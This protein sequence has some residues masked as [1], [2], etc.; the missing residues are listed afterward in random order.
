MK[1]LVSTEFIYLFPLGSI[2]VSDPRNMAARPEDVQE[3]APQEYLSRAF[4]RD[5]WWQLH[6]AG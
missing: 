2:L 5:S 1:L 4:W 3:L 6:S